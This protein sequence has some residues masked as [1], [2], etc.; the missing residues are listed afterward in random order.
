MNSEIYARAG[1][2]SAPV[3]EYD[4]TEEYLLKLRGADYIPVRKKEGYKNKKSCR[5]VLRYESPLM[6]GINNARPHGRK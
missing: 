1:R 5:D 3:F 2:N 6:K 4:F